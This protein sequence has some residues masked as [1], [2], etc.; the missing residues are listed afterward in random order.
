M[1]MYV[2][3]IMHVRTCIYTCIC[4]IK[5]L[6]AFECTYMYIVIIHTCIR[7]HT[8]AFIIHVP[9][10]HMHTCLHSLTYIHTHTHTNTHTQFL[11]YVINTIYSKQDVVDVQF[12]GIIESDVIDPR[13]N[14]NRSKY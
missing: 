5:L 6:H 4:T 11:R 3:C 7:V 14:L 1:Y 13:R 2:Q 10:I 9:N 8:S 12:S